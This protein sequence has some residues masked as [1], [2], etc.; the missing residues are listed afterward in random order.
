M[1]SLDYLDHLDSLEPE[2]MT[3]CL[4]VL[5]SLARLDYLLLQIYSRTGRENWAFLEHQDYLE[6]EELM[7]FLD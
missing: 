2:E 3:V 4:D 6:R 5:V 1:T 7:D